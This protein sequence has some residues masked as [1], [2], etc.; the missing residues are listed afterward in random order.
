MNELV[1]GIAKEMLKAAES[2]SRA[3]NVPALAGIFTTNRL[4]VVAKELGYEKQ[5]EIYYIRYLVDGEV[6]IVMR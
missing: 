4:Q 2:L 5:N 6:S 3:A 1:S